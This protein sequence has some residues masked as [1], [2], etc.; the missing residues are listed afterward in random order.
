MSAPSTTQGEARSQPTTGCYVYGLLPGDVELNSEVLGVGDPPA[1]VRLVRAGDDL[2]AM[3]SDVDLSRPFG[4]PE[5]L[6]A[7]KEILDSAA[8]GSPVL[9][10]RFGTV[11]T[12]EDAVV[13]ELLEP[14]RAEFAAAL[15]ELEG[16]AEYVIHGRYVERVIL[17]EI[18]SQ[19]AA[20]AKLADQIRAANPDATRDLR[21]RLG[22]LINEAVA[23]RRE[24]DTRQLLPSIGDQCRASFVRQPTHE[25]DAV[26]VAVLAD[27]DKADEL[28]K[29]VRDVASAWRERTE[30]RLLGPMAPY[31]FVAADRELEG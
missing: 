14:H 3:V 23:A 10:V 5:D 6:R 2:A 18:L 22:E 27:L 12:G 29:A 9:P 20:A 19:N 13:S 4:N 24:K 21:I 26:Y 30:L 28:E 11:L 16:T 1:S 8:L 7:H 31:D 17:A 15:D 25:L